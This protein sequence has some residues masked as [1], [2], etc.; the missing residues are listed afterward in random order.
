MTYEHLLEI[1]SNTTNSIE[2]AK[3]KIAEDEYISVKQYLPMQDKIEMVQ[4][5]TNIAFDETMGMI[6]PTKRTIAEAIAYM[7]Y[8][9]GFEFDPTQNLTAAYDT[10]DHHGLINQVFL[11]IPEKEKRA[12]N[13]LIN[14]NLEVIDKYNLSAA[15]TMRTLLTTLDGYL[16]KINKIIKEMPTPPEGS[17]EADSGKK[18]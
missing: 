2:E 9:A 18:E 1:L 14:N 10:F 6:S 12:I 15:G 17:I 3:V 13:I 11:A 8:Y 4:F 7:I 5:I 16:D